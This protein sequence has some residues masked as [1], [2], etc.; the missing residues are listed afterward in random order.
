MARNPELFKMKAPKLGYD[1]W[2]KRLLEFLQR[3]KQLGT[4]WG[5]DCIENPQERY[6]QY[7]QRYKDEAH[8][9]EIHGNEF[10][11]SFTQLNGYESL[12]QP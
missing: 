12:W 10:E 3:E 1:E 9:V 11:H 4:G 7:C 6:E 5:R 8:R 2:H